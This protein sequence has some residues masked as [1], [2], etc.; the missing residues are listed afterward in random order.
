MNPLS[1][2]TIYSKFILHLF[3]G[4]VHGKKGHTNPNLLYEEL[5]LTSHRLVAHCDSQEDSD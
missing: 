2:K 4:C 1:L 5:T 3:K